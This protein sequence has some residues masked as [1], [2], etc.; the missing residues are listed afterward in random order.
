MSKESLKNAERIIGLK[1][2]SLGYFKPNVK[3]EPVKL[4][5]GYKVV[6]KVESSIPYVI[7]KVDYR[8]SEVEINE[9][10]L[11]GKVASYSLINRI[12][13]ELTEKYLEKGYYNCKVNVRTAPMKKERG[14]VLVKLLVEIKP[15][16]RYVVKFKGNKN[17]SSKKLEKLITFR[18]A[19]SVDPFEIENSKKN[20]VSYYKDN[21]FPFASVKVTKID[22]GKEVVITFKVKEGK[23]VIIK[24]VEGLSPEKAKALLQKPYSESRI[25]NLKYE[26]LSDLKSKG[27]VKAKFF[28][29]ISP[30]GVLR[31]RVERGA[32]Y[33]IT[34]VKVLG[35]KLH[36]FKGI[37]LPKPYTKSF[38]E[39]LVGE[40]SDFYAN[41]GYPDVN[42][43]YEKREKGKE[44]NRVSLEVVFRIKPGKGYK[45]GFVLFKGLERTKLRFI[46]NL[47]VIM[48]GETYSKG[49]ALEQYSVLVDSGLFSNVN[50]EEVK[51][52]SYISEIVNLQEG[53]L[54]KGNGFIGYGSD[55]GGVVNGFL[56]SSSPLGFGLK[57]FVFGKYRQKEGYDAIFKTVKPAFPFKNWSVSY[58]IV[59]KEQ[60][61][62]SFKSD[63][64]IYN[65]AA[66]RKKTKAFSQIFRLEISREKV[67]DTSIKIKKRFLER[68]F[69][70]S[71]IY[72]KRDNR[73]NP[74]KGFLSHLNLSIA[75]LFLGGDTDFVSAEEKFL[76]LFSFGM[77]TVATRIHLGV[78]NS[79][80]GKSVPLQN[81][82]FLG[83]AE[84]IR[85]Y[86]YGTVSPK[87]DKGNYVG[88]KAYG[89][90]SVEVR[91]NLTQNLQ[92]A[93]FYDSGKVFKTP[94][95]FS[96]S[97]WYSSVGFG[98]RYIT[99]VGPLRLDYGYKLKEIPGQGRGRFHI[100]FGFP[101]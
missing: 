35:D 27:Y 30:S 73:V 37:K 51:E 91:R 67:K 21:G 2:E 69:V 31:V 84:S 17:V 47:K 12:R 76:Y 59:K 6:I 13:N 18:K 46:K 16:K 75:G 87:D 1:L 72:D 97:N 57:Y 33:Q 4:K 74:K 45:F 41:N 50:I 3:V 71:Q 42:V 49:K 100:S 10:E 19:A 86:K 95:Q 56:S 20:I 52:S 7:A 94:S 98:I 92:G 36:F 90:F 85:G 83:G 89:F 40:I 14:K 34:S 64:V 96:F 81:R 5:C 61:Y 62:E 11:L 44:K 9:K 93:L 78:I 25:R 54:L 99:P 43:S 70:Y 15:G 66:L 26:V 8:G 101:F 38:V 29:E 48:P 65:F 32:L 88:G 79:L 80:K 55:S 23:K 58:S 82:F 77:E 22:K 63:K 68:R 28:Y 24:K 53:S 60:I 39:D